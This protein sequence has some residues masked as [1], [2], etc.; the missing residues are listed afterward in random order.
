MFRREL[1]EN[2]EIRFPALPRAE[3]FYFTCLAFALAENIAI[4]DKHTVLYHNDAGSGS[5][6]NAKDRFP[7]AQLVARDMLYEKLVELGLYD[8]LKQ[9]FVSNTINSFYYHLR[10]FNTGTA[11]EATF[12]YFRD[13]AI[14]K[15]GIDMSD[16]RYFHVP[17]EYR[18]MK[19]VAD[20]ESSTDFVYKM[21][22][23]EKKKKSREMAT[24]G[25]A[26]SGDAAE[27]RKSWSYKIGR[28]ITWLPRKLRIFFRSWRDRGFR[29][30][31]SRVFQKLSSVFK[32]KD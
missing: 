18:Y 29:Y 23:E 24:S 13:V 26:R 3:D 19:A 9:T 21:Y 14:E 16:A 7:E 32:K 31:M 28:F 12:N 11:F 25:G 27:I 8:T 5:L 20:A 30:T 4:L 10:T 6:E 17:V 15:Y 1:L 22:V 2:P